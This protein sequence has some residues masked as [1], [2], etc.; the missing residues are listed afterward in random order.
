IQDG[1]L[2]SGETV[3]LASSASLDLKFKHDDAIISH[4]FLKVGFSFLE[5]SASQHKIDVKD[6]VI[7]KKI[8]VASPILSAAAS[9]GGGAVPTIEPDFRQLEPDLK[10]P[11]QAF[12]KTARALAD[13]PA[14]TLSLNFSKISFDYKE[15][16]ADELKVGEDFLTLAKNAE[17]FKI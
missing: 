4:D 12:L 2:V 8:D 15:Q 13:H 10:A 5:A 6:I 1:T 17:Q 11:A 7:I 9:D 14:E 16:S 3:S